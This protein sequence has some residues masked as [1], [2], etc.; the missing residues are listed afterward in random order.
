[1]IGLELQTSRSEVT[2]VPTEPQPLPENYISFKNI[3]SYDVRRIL[4]TI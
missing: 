2:A 1:M 4:K 3:I